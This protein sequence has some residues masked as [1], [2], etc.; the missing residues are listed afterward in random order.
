MVKADRQRSV[1]PMKNLPFVLYMSGNFVKT[2]NGILGILLW[3][4]PL[5]VLWRPPLDHC[6]GGG[7]VSRGCRGSR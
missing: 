6:G 5:D 3:C 2:V 4:P 1:S 7:D